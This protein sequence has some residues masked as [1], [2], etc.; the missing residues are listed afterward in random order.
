MGNIAEAEND[1]YR[2]QGFT[3][4]DDWKNIENQLNNVVQYLHMVVFYD[5]K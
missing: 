2:T 3:T 1:F 4:R 5:F